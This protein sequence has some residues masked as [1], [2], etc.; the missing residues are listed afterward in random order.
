M[1]SWAGSMWR[2]RGLK[3]AKSPPAYGQDYDAVLMGG[4]MYM[5]ENKAHEGG[6]AP[7]RP[8]EAVHRHLLSDKPYDQ[9]NVTSGKP[10]TPFEHALFNHAHKRKVP[11][12][13]VY[14]LDTQTTPTRHDRGG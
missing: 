8:G 9:S 1:G 6:T 12:I 5:V 7:P 10:S 2:D 4:K 11:K 3:K 14:G 13:C